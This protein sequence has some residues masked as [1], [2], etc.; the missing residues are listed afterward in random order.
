MQF[1]RAEHFFLYPAVSGSTILKR[2]KAEEAKGSE[3]KMPTMP[4][5]LFFGDWVSD[6]RQRGLWL[7]FE[8]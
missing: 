4:K 8:G 1:D 3:V 5:L 6:D 2:T 7:T